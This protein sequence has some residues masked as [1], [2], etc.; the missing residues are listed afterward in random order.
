MMRRRPCNDA[1]IK[2]RRSRSS[3][4]LACDLRASAH[5]HAVM[6]TSTRLPIKGPRKRVHGNLSLQFM[7]LSQLFN[8]KGGEIRKVTPA[9]AKLVCV[10]P[11]PR[12]G[13]PALPV[14]RHI[15]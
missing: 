8:A 2:N 11:I 7:A 4:S 5:G 15:R 1:A 9:W 6:P 10:G 3:T 13:H 12:R 14:T